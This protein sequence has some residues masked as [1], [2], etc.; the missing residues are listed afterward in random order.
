[1]HVVASPAADALEENQ[2][3]LRGWDVVDVGDLAPGTLADLS[4]GA[5]RGPPDPHYLFVGVR[6]RPPWYNV[7]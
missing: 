6:F 7:T 2:A 3:R 1:M 4:T 5:R